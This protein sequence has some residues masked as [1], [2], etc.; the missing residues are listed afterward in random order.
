MKILEHYINLCCQTCVSQKP[1]KPTVIKPD[2]S[3]FILLYS[4]YLVTWFRMATFM[5]RML[6]GKARA[7]SMLISAN[8]G[9]A[10]I[11]PKGS[12]F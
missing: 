8:L 3:C 12:F 6:C 2:S 11:W 9:K 5:S 7:G 1:N 10:Q 4:R